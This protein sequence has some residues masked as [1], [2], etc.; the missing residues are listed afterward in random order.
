MLP[1]SLRAAIAGLRCKVPKDVKLPASIT[2]SLGSFEE[3]LK[4]AN[5]K[6][7]KEELDA[8]IKDSPVEKA[9]KA[10]SKCTELV[11]QVIEQP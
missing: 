9:E 3:V 4:Q 2:V 1:Q 11:M 5:I 8:A 7:I 10:L 6:K